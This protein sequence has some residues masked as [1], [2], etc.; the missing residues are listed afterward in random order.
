VSTPDVPIALL[1]TYEPGSGAARRWRSPKWNLQLELEPLS[2]TETSALAEG[3]LG[4]PLS[5]ELA[6]F[7]WGRSLGNPLYVQEFVSLLLAE[8]RLF[9][10]ARRFSLA[11]AASHVGLPAP[12]ESILLAR[13]DLLERDEREAV[14]IAAVL[15]VELDERVLLAVASRLSPAVGNLERVIER[16]VEQGVLA[17]REANPSSLAFRHAL[18]QET[19]YRSMLGV[20]RRAL[21]RLA[22]LA[23]E[24]A[25]VDS[26]SVD[27]RLLARHFVRSGDRP[28]AARWMAPALARAEEGYDHEGALALAGEFLRLAGDDP[29]LIEA[30]LEVLAHRERTLELIGRRAEQRAD[31]EEMMRLATQRGD[32]SRLAD[33]KNRL[34][35]FFW[36]SA[37]DFLVAKQLALDALALK[38]RVDDAHGEAAA[39]RNLGSICYYLGGFDEATEHHRRALEVYRRCGD[40]EGEAACLCSVAINMAAQLKL[41]EALRLLDQ[42]LAIDR[43]IGNRRGEGRERRI[44]GDVLRE[45]GRY[46]QAAR[47]YTLALES[48]RSI[49]HEQGA[50][51]N[52]ANL[53]ATRLAEGLVDEAL[54]LSEE[55]LEAASAIEATHVLATAQLLS[56]KALRARGAGGDLEKALT[57]AQEAHQA[58]RARGLWA[59]EVHA[60][61]EVGIALTLLGRTQEGL[62]RLEGANRRVGDRPHPDL[63]SLE[64]MLFYHRALL[65]A[66]QVDPARKVLVSVRERVESRAASID[67]PD[68]AHDYRT[69]VPLNREILAEDEPR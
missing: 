27:P 52:V 42:A 68:L 31:I 47:N 33:A 9:K 10:R 32:I 14:Q 50:A 55:A 26:A 60:Q 8:G 57:L 43:E 25:A 56:A 65:L 48:D 38:R 69:C 54:R 22:G 44:M 21:H 2:P 61:A 16:L 4:R 19:A 67:D 53:A 20:N 45:A 5:T 15:G 41:G 1:A 30:K 49:G 12:I 6:A 51:L 39:L 64:I 36:W 37:A 28:R 18:V 24:E 11:R 59:L 66:G 3:L 34:S 35:W 13:L 29:T 63:P 17:R 46:D 58:A 62:A 40:R 7:V 23:L